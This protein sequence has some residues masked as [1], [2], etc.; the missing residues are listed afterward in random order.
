MAAETDA[1][2]AVPCRFSQHLRDTFSPRPL[3][4]LV[5]LAEVDNTAPELIPQVLPVPLLTLRQSLYGR[6]PPLHELQV[7]VRVKY[8]AD[9]Q[10]QPR[11]WEGC[12]LSRGAE[13]SDV[14]QG[15]FDLICKQVKIKINQTVVSQFS[16]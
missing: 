14:F 2:P 4:P 1:N 3:A 8:R 12:G 5:R 9:R 6:I 11:V 16:L 10:V 15:C 7:T 13:L